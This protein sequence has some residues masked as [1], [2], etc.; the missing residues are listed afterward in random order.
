[1]TNDEIGYCSECGTSV[2]RHNRGDILQAE[3]ANLKA[4]LMDIRD[5]LWTA[6]RMRD[7]ARAALSGHREADAAA[8]PSRGPEASLARAACPCCGCPSLY[9]RDG[10]KWCAYVTTCG[11][12][13]ASS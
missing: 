3:N 11:Y 4:A 5:G 9:G 1:M 13:E 6:E 12:V 10:P 2:C 7:I 8:Q